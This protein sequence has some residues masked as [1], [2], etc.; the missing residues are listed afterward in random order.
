VHLIGLELLNHVPEHPYVHRVVGHAA[1]KLGNLQEANDHLTQALRGEDER[2]QAKCLLAEI[3]REQLRFSQADQLIAEAIASQPCIPQFWY[4]RADL[5]MYRG[6]YTQATKYGR[7]A[8]QLAPKNENYRQLLRLAE[9]YS[10]APLANRREC[11]LDLIKATGSCSRKAQ[12]IPI[13]TLGSRCFWSAAINEPRLPQ[14]IE[15]CFACAR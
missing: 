5:A 14:V 7:Q 12:R 6:E 8:V 11:D 10:R 1:L 9:S 15:K 13:Y 4:A 2:D 3:C